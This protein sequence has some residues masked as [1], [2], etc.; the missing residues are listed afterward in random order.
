MGWVQRATAQFEIWTVASDP[1]PCLPVEPSL[2]PYVK[3]QHMGMAMGN[4]M[5]PLVT[6]PGSSWMS[7]LKVYLY[8]TQLFDTWNFERNTFY[9]SITRKF[10]EKD[11]LIS[12]NIY[13]HNF[14]ILLWLMGLREKSTVHLHSLWELYAV[15]DKR[16]NVV[17]GGPLSWI[18]GIDFRV[19]RTLCDR[20]W[21]LQ[22]KL[23]KREP[24]SWDPRQRTTWSGL[25]TFDFN[26]V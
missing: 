26:S 14:K 2:C 4:S 17:R 23:T 8:C 15:K 1:K 12:E 3:K 5:V 6:I 20:L 21:N 13:L 7:F 11:S 18:P 19:M 9:E 25:V 10:R 22:A 16:H 24:H